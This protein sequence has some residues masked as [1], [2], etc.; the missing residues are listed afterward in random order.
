MIYILVIKELFFSIISSIFVVL[1]LYILMKKDIL[2]INNKAIKYAFTD[3]L[4]GLYNRHY[5]NDFLQK[6]SSLRKE[7]ANF[8][9]L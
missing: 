3:G 9:I 5:L 6:F 8:A 4:T 7:D 1:A 2:V